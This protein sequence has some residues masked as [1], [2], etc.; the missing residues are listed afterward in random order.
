[1]RKRIAY[2]RYHCNI[3][4]IKPD[5]AGTCGFG[6]RIAGRIFNPDCVFLLYMGCQQF[7]KKK[8]IEAKQIG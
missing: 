8:Y 7:G 5:N 6:W 2:V 3:E 1:M 4:R